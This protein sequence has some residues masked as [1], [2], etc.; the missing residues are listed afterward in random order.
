MQNVCGTSWKFY[1]A[2]QRKEAEEEVKQ[3]K[4]KQGVL[5]V[6]KNKFA[7]EDE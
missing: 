2:S 1:D 6:G 3:K 4:R 7:N 5:F